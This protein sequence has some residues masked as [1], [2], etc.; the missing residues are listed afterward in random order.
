MTGFTGLPGIAH[1]AE[2]AAALASGRPAYKQAAATHQ[3]D[4][5]TAAVTVEAWLSL[6]QARVTEIAANDERL[7]HDTLALAGPGGFIVGHSGYSPD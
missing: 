3:A 5:E 4:T 6:L 2:G 1:I 7:T